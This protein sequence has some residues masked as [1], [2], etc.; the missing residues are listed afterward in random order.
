MTP[1]YYIYAH[2][3]ADTEE[4]FYI[5]KGKGRRAWMTKKTD[6]RNIW[7]QRIAKKHG[8]TVKLLWEGLTEYE[9][10]MK[11]QEL[12]TQYGRRDLGTGPLVNL[13][14]GGNGGTN[15][16]EATRKKRSQS[17]KQITDTP[18]YR[19]T[20][21]ARVQ[22]YWDNNPDQKKRVSEQLKKTLANPVIREERRQLAL[23]QWANDP[24]RRQRASQI[25]KSKSKRYEGICDPTGQFHGP[26]LNLRDFCALHNL[27][28]S[29]L[30]KVLTGKAQHH[31]GW[32]L[33]PA[34]RHLQFFDFK[35]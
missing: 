29:N 24:E 10:Y 32:R 11:E 14:D 17:V 20:L 18:E 16:G 22:T 13:T 7:W 19:R 15:I 35:S 6:G 1:P 27:E 34:Q 21:R 25:A 4:L 9:A 2:Y 31:R 28:Y 26:I 3:T 33:P 5:G 8:F 30:W 12:I 23:A